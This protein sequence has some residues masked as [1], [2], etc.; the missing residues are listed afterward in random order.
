MTPGR[1]ARRCAPAARSRAHPAAGGFRPARSPPSGARRPPSPTSPEFLDR[2][3]KRLVFGRGLQ[4]LVPD[5]AGL[6]ALAHLP[7]HL[8]EVRAD[9]GIGA[10]GVG[11]SPRR[12]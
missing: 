6:V 4:R 12:P 1:S 9:L 11:A 3:E 7:E 2:L 8:A 10:A 5:A